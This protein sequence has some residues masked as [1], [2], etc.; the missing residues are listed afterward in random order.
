[1]MILRS[2]A[3]PVAALVAAVLAVAASALNGCAPVV[4]AA[5]VGAGVLVATDRRSTGAQVDDEAIELK[6]TT[7]A[8]SRWGNAIHLNVTSFNGVVFLTGEAPTLAVQDEITQLAKSTDRVRTVQNEMVIGPVT[9][10]SA[11]TN[12]SYITSKVKT[13]FV[14]ANKFA[15]N[16]VKVVTERSVVYLMGIVS[17]EEGAAAAQIASTTSGVARVVK[18]F[19]YTN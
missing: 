9:D 16:R 13:R 10:L 12:D 4:V 5:A 1:M 6:V 3:R 17:R 7:E 19:E 15:P 14:E 18:V 2:H 11:R 8:G